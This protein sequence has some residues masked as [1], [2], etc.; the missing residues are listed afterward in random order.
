M[1]ERAVTKANLQ[2]HQLEHI[3][4]AFH[5]F[6]QQQQELLQEQVQ[7]KQQ[8]QTLLDGGGPTT[9]TRDHESMMGGVEMTAALDGLG[10]QVASA[11]VGAH[12][13]QS[14]RAAGW[15]VPAPSATTAATKE[16]AVACGESAAGA[17]YPAG[18]TGA[19]SALSNGSRS[20]SSSTV[21]AAA[22]VLPVED[23]ER[24]D[25]LLQDLL[26]IARSLKQHSRHLVCMWMDLLTAEQHADVLLAGYPWSINIPAMC[27][28]V[29]QAQQANVDGK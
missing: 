12:P 8:L 3:C 20:R 4:S 5:C 14:T 2:P 15:P 1:C 25:E 24:A 9:D 6:R 22:G 21:D 27:A 17:S 18:A 28:C 16:V 10:E 11:A 13:P 26:R 23:A 19:N 29:W 7:V